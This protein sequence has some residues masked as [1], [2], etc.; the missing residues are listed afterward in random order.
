MDWKEESVLMPYIKICRLKKDTSVF[1]KGQKL[2]L[3]DHAGLNNT[4]KTVF[5]MGR[6]KKTGRYISAYVHHY[7]ILN[8]RFEITQDFAYYLYRM[9]G[10]FF[11]PDGMKW[12]A[13]K[14]M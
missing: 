3:R 12:R 11:W 13:I 5:A 1:K 14:R 7:K 8:P 6:Y 10:K 2:F 9:S 4:K